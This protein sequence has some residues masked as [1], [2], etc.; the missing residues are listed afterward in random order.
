[1]RARLTGGRKGSTEIILQPGSLCCGTQ[2]TADP[3][4]AGSICLIMQIAVRA[5]NVCTKSVH[6]FFWFVYVS[7]VIA[8]ST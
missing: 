1:M 8:C 7:L 6:L 2:F 5:L 3:G 4:T